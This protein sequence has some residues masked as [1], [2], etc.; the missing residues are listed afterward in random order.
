[1]TFKEAKIGDV[2][3]EGLASAT[4]SGTIKKCSGM[5]VTSEASKALSLGIRR[6][7]I[8]TGT[9]IEDGREGVCSF[10]VHITEITT[11]DNG[12]RIAFSAVGNPYD[13]TEKCPNP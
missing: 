5:L 3:G 8:F 13:G 1:M 4:K 9:L 6:S 7:A 12:A 11:I 10:P 2:E